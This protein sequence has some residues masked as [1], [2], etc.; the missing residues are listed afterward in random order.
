MLDARKCEQSPSQAQPVGS[1][2][3]PLDEQVVGEG[4]HRPEL[5]LDVEVVAEVRLRERPLE[6][7]RGAEHRAERA[8][9]A[10]HERERRRLPGFGLQGRS[11]PE[12]NREV[13]PS[14]AGE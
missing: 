6:P 2:P 4:E 10:E 9:V 1:A 5:S 12:A 13:A 14:V 8:R 7:E 11:V 3:L